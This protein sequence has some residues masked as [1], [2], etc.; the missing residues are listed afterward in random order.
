MGLKD[1]LK[2]QGFIQDEG[3]ESTE[4]EKRTRQGTS[5]AVKSES[6]VF[7]PI[8]QNTDIPESTPEGADPSFVA[9]LQKS[10]G[11]STKPDANFV[12]FFEDELVKANLEGPDYFEFRQQLI[13]TQQKMSAKGMVAS[14][15][16]LQ[17]V[18]TS[19]EAQ[20]ISTDKLVQAA[21]HYKEV[22]KQK[23]DEFIRGAETEKNNQLQKR[24]NVLNSHTD[25]I[26]KL[27]QQIQQLDLQK[28]QLTESLDKEKTQL[29]VN[30]TL[31]QEG[32]EKIDKAEHLI[33]IAYEYMKSTIDEDIKKLK[34]V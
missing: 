1:F 13:K 33:G 27:Q 17:A 14:D 29:E 8:Q 26:Q 30:K 23:N 15:V 12:K 20:G 3:P 25:N 5:P 31:G 22:I 2:K 24:Q 4:N 18:I 6:P 21:Q 16:I 10:T 7:F 32:I 34:S 9:P 19:F 11:K 28:Q